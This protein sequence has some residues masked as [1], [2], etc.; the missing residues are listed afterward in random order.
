MNRK[1]ISVIGAGSWGTAL[2]M[3]LTNNGHDVTL[4]S[5]AAEHVEDMKLNGKNRRY[6]P[7]VQLP[8]ELNFTCDLIKA[9]SDRD[10]IVFSVPAQSFGHVFKQVIQNVKRDAI[11]VNTAKGIETSSLKVLSEVAR[12]EMKL[13]DRGDCNF[14]VLSGPSHAEEVAILMPTTV[15]CAAW[16]TE[17]ASAVQN[18]FMS[19]RFRV[20]TNDD[21]VGLE[22]GGALKNII[23]LGAGICDGLGFGD[24]TKAALMTRGLSEICRLGIT[25]G[26]KIETFYGLGGMGDLIVTCTSKHS[27]NRNCGLLLGQGYAPSIAIKKVGM[28]VEGVSTC[29]AAYLLSKKL[30][31]EM[32]INNVIHGILKDEIKADDAVDLLMEREGRSENF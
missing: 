14:A 12:E 5:R 9:A 3:V 11:I 20:Y 10:I 22:L 15:S 28:V 6:L 29:E 17:T 2:A 19:S 31:V 26:A 25:M 16:N 30:D 23:A 21:L 4:Y 18:V 13:A 1:R 7:N 8:K 24:N 27:R 32:P